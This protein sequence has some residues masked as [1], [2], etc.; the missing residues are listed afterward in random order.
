MM[1]PRVAFARRLTMPPTGSERLIGA[2]RR[3]GG[4]CG[5][6]RRRQFWDAL[7]SRETLEHLALGSLN[8]TRLRRFLRRI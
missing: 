6:Y 4:D 7:T 3:L 8:P 2:W 1:Q 5:G